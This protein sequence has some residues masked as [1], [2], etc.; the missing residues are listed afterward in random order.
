MI[1]M[2]PLLKEQDK[3]YTWIYNFDVSLDGGDPYNNYHTG[4]W[5]SSYYQSFD[6]A[7]FPFWFKSGVFIEVDW[8]DGTVETI[9]GDDSIGAFSNKAFHAY[10]TPAEVYRISIKSR[11]WNR[12]WL[13]GGD[14]GNG[15]Y[16]NSGY[17][18]RWYKHSSWY[19]SQLY[20]DPDYITGIDPGFDYGGLFSFIDSPDGFSRTITGQL[21]AMRMGCQSIVTPLPPVAGILISDHIHVAND[22]WSYAP[23][24]YL[25]DTL[26][27][28]GTF[29]PNSMFYAFSYY[30]ILKSAPSNLF[31]N[32]L[33]STDFT[34][35]LWC[36]PTN[37]SNTIQYD[38]SK[39]KNYHEYYKTT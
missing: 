22:D 23:S 20:G 31:A 24:D 29:M 9:E 2:K 25:D 17:P 39:D 30:C 1:Q 10:N 3:E 16:P 27:P 4:W 15:G 6:T 28:F 8:G 12:I 18:G 34:G 21:A 13:C 14:C 38:Q 5:N 35:C 11:Q 36:V 19:A 37:V 26:F 32:N 7:S 33:N